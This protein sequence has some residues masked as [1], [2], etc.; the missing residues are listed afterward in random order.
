MDEEINN[1]LDLSLHVFY[2]DNLYC[3]IMPINNGPKIHLVKLH[4]SFDLFEYE[5]C[6]GSLA[7]DATP[8]TNIL[9]LK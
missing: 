2:F 6:L 1:Y 5:L 9:F 4:F 3:Y 7:G 8:N